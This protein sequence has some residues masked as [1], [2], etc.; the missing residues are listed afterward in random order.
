M[1]LSRVYPEVLFSAAVW[2]FNLLIIVMAFIP[3]VIS[4]VLRNLR[5]KT[6][7]NK[8]NSTAGV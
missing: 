6:K 8:S 7:Y 3:D 4:I 2:V 1:I 5:V